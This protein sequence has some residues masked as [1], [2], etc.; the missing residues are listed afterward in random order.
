MGWANLQYP[1]DGAEA[2]KAAVNEAF[3]IAPTPTF[4][5][6]VIV[7]LQVRDARLQ[8]RVYN[9]R[10]QAREATCSHHKENDD[11]KQTETHTRSIV[12]ATTIAHTIAP[13][14]LAV[15]KPGLLQHVLVV[16]DHR[17][18]C[19]RLVS[20]NSGGRHGHLRRLLLDGH[21]LVHV[22][23]VNVLRIVGAV[24]RISSK[25]D[26]V[27]HG[28]IRAHRRR[29]IQFVRRSRRIKF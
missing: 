13:T 18:G 17:H 20:C 21:H 24:L 1:T 6:R 4:G 14:P 10:T 16:R 5:M 26:W 7:A 2:A 25:R 22:V 27:R 29:P 11:L 19:P 9:A 15:R 12:F 23:V 3:R 8:L 28:R